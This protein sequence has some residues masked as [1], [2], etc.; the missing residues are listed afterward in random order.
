MKPGQ[1]PGAG[2]L[3][4]LMCPRGPRPPPLTPGWREHRTWEQAR[5]LLSTL[6]RGRGSAR[7]PAQ[8]SQDGRQDS[9][10]QASLTVGAWRSSSLPTAIG[11]LK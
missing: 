11:R 7:G 9:Y 5:F 6:Q 4:P 2:S 3:V 8:G 1:D 10:R